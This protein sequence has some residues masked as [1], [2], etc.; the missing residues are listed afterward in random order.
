MLKTATEHVEKLEKQ[1]LSFKQVVI[2]RDGQLEFLKDLLKTTQASLHTERQPSNNDAAQQQQQLEAARR[3]IAELEQRNPPRE[4]LQ[5]QQQEQQLE[6]ARR[7]IAELEQM[8]NLPRE[9][10]QQLEAARQRI[11]ELE[12]MRN[13]PREEMQQQQQQQLIEK[14]KKTLRDRDALIAEYLD[15]DYK[16]ACNDANAAVADL[17]T[18]PLPSSADADVGS[19]SGSGS[20]IID[21]ITPDGPKDK[22]VRFG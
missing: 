8:R 3:R 9:E 6:A 19:S 20:G 22:S 12:Q 11:A 14:L 7:R 16:I 5:Q 21:I 10:L 17:V 4:V 1:R 15:I 2:D 13:L 18:R